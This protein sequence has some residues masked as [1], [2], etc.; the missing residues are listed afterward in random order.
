MNRR[1]LL[2]L[3]LILAAWLPLAAKEKILI[4]A[5]S[6]QA[7]FAE[8]INVVKDPEV[9]D[10]FEVDFVVVN[11]Q[12]GYDSFENAL[13]S[14]EPDLLILMDNAA[15]ELYGFYQKRNPDKTFPPALACMAAL[16]KEVI[17]DTKNIIGVSYEVSALQSY[18]ALAGIA[19]RAINS[20][21]VIYFQE[22]QAFIDQQRQYTSREEIE[23]VGYSIGI[24]PDSSKRRI[25]REL[26]RGLRHLRRNADVIWILNDI[27]LIEGYTEVW[28]RELGKARKPVIVS[29]E[30]LMNPSLGNFGVYPDHAEIGT[31]LVDLIY[32]YRN[33]DLILDGR[34]EAPRS[35]LTHLDATFAKKNLGLKEDPSL[36][37]DKVDNQ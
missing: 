34:V 7:R 30:S 26:T 20:V 16:V 32:D 3:L 31:Q 5:P 21:G 36:V 28:A 12:T 23:L 9:L 35:Y 11:P 2:Q 22:Q 29:S 37:A 27:R 33:G 8:V 13:K 4:M 24:S 10:H 6:Q 25:S 14:R 17:R 15:V 1:R 18:T 19:N